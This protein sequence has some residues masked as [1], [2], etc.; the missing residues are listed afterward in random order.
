M[1]TQRSFVRAALGCRFGLL[2]A[3]GLLTLL[4]SAAQDSAA[5]AL[6]GYV[7][8]GATGDRLVGA[9]V[10]LVDQKRET[11][12]A[13]DGSYEIDGLAPG[14]HTLTV[15]YP[16]LDPQTVTIDVSR[17]ADARK[18]IAL[19]SEIYKLSQFVVAGEREGNAAA[20]AA[21]RNA[22]NVQNVVTADAFGSMAKGNVGQLSPAA[23]R[24][25]RHQ[26]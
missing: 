5:G 24:H 18:D 19:N 21:Q 8:N 20:I 6:R 23:P 10:V 3:L 17:A 26:R 1:K 13:R 14:A 9:R 12:T 2:A 4:P 22:I 16:G 25:R 15:E 7:S 11:L